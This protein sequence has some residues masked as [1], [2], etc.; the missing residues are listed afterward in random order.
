MRRAH[1]TLHNVA[2]FKAVALDLIGCNIDVVGRREV[3]IVAWTEEAIAIRH[4]FKDAIC[5]NNVRKVEVFTH[6]SCRIHGRILIFRRRNPTISRHCRIVEHVVIGNRSL[7]FYRD[8]KHCNKVGSIAG[9]AFPNAIGNR[10][11]CIGR[12]FVVRFNLRLQPCNHLIIGQIGCFLWIIRSLCRFW[13]DG[14]IVIREALLG[15]IVIVVCAFFY[16]ICAL[17]LWIVFLHIGKP[18]FKFIY[19]GL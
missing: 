14:I 13:N 7:V 3:V 9:V 19:S 8:I 11:T 15:R 6:I 12:C 16:T 1:V 10:F 18:C 4:D 5:W 2:R 17:S